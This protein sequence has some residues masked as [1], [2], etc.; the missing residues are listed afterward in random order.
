MNRHLSRM[1]VM[2]AIYEWNFRDQADLNEILERSIAEFADDIDKVFVKEEILGVSKHRENLDRE[3]EVSA[4][5][6]P[7]EQ[8][9][10][11]D[12]SILE[13]A[14]YELIYTDDIPPK[15]SINEAI[16]LAKQFG[17]NNSG[18]FIN[19]VLGTI[20]EKHRDKVEKKA[21]KNE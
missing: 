13:I 17:S 21:G 12:K 7:I 19:G 11:I 10:T 1:V 2:Q 20:Y 15:V 9:S 4:P 8:I 16:E 6:W 3:I 18:K 5:E 14:I